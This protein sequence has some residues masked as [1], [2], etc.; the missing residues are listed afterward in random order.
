MTL[1]ALKRKL[2]T[3]FQEAGLE[4][5][6]LEARWIIQHIT[7]YNSA[8]MIV[9]SA[10][11]IPDNLITHINAMA[12]RRIGG[13]PM[14]N[15]LGYREFYGG[16]ID[17]S[18]DVLSPR[19]ETEGLVDIALEF[20]ENVKNP[21]VLDLGTGSGAII[22]S[23]LAERPDA[24]G[25]GTDLSGMALRTAQ[26]NAR[27]RG[28]FTRLTCLQSDWFEDIKGSFDLIVSNPPYITDAAMET[29]S[30][31]VLGFDPELALRGGPDGLAPYH[32][33]TR[34]AAAHIKPSGGLIFEIGYDQ[35]KAVS[36]LMTE[37]G[38]GD[39]TIHKDLAGHDR[40]VSGRAVPKVWGPR[41]RGTH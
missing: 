25:L 1:D 24:K 22:I 19:Q 2:I 35:G 3:G 9:K 7:G 30:P 36:T 23:I 15:I 13:E 39:V 8:D 41:S 5:P 17:V 12:A 32:I 16:R 34:Q 31:E 6:A 33:I 10:D 21:H 40:I 28:V 20:L 29:L 26:Y 4:S 27:M 18:K 38:Y 11:E 14:D 37:Q